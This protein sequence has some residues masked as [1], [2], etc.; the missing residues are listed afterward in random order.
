MHWDWKEFILTFAYFRKSESISIHSGLLRTSCFHFREYRRYIAQYFGPHSEI[1]FMN[2]FLCLII[3]YKHRKTFRLF[4]KNREWK[5]FH[6]ASDC[7][8]YNKIR[9]NI[10]KK[11]WYENYKSSMI[12]SRYLR[13]LLSLFKKCQSSRVHLSEPFSWFSHFI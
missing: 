13:F 3:C 10:F 1:Q 8:K 6:D 5:R 4:R 7:N 12:T 2:W 11:L 9:D